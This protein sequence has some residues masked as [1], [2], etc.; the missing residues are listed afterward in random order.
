MAEVLKTN[1]MPDKLIPGKK[2]TMAYRMKHQ[3][4][5]SAFPFK[6]P[7]KDETKKGT[8][9]EPFDVRNRPMT[10]DELDKAKINPVSGMNYYVNIKTGETV[11]TKNPKS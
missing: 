2:R 5:P 7:M 11:V 9:K 8:K 1:N 10:K 4:N 6:S 3:G